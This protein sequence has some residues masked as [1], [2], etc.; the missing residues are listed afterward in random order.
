MRDCGGYAV[1]PDAKHIPVLA[2]LGVH[3]AAINFCCNIAKA[4]LDKIELVQDMH[5]LVGIMIC[6]KQSAEHLTGM[7]SCK[8]VSEGL[9]NIG[10]GSKQRG[11]VG[12]APTGCATALLMAVCAHVA[13]SVK[14]EMPEV[15][16]SCT[17]WM[18][19]G[20]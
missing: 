4:C 14:E 19:Y 8:S 12:Q 3:A 2:R 17:N 6:Y 7:L 16:A 1:T 18:V 10:S 5:L 9:H 11:V 20:F 13:T 15:A